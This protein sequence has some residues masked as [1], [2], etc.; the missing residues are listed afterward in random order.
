MGDYYVDIDP[1]E[2]MELRLHGVLLIAGMVKEHQDA[3]AR[4]IRIIPQCRGEA[5]CTPRLD[6]M[7]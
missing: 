3:C 2:R 5:A 6:A 4:S 1:K 7:S